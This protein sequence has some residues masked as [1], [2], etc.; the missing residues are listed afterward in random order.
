MGT[1]DGA[2]SAGGEL[3][4]RAT[5][6]LRAS[7]IHILGSGLVLVLGIV[8]PIQVAGRAVKRRC[9]TSHSQDGGAIPRGSAPIVAVASVGGLA[10][11]LV[12]MAPMI[13]CNLPRVDC[14]CL[15]MPLPAGRIE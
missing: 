4:V 10:K 14:G 7:F 15:E 3:N 12:R 2:E 6:E 1:V 13:R 9:D 8:C 5:G 11:V